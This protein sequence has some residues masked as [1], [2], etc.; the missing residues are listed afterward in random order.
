MA[1]LDKDMISQPELWKLSLLLADKHLDVALFPPTVREEMI[2]RHFDFPA[3]A[4]DPLRA[5]EDIIYENPLLFSD[6]KRVECIIDNCQQILTPA[7]LDP[8]AT[9]RVYSELTTLSPT[10]H[11][12]ALPDEPQIFPT[13][14]PTC[15]VALLQKADIDAFI[16]RTFYNVRF[17]SRLA[18]LIRY[19]LSLP[20]TPE[21]PSMFIITRNGRL[22]LIA[23]KTGRVLMANTFQY[24]TDADAAY[25]ILACTSSLSLDPADLTL[26]LSG[27][28]SALSEIVAPYIPSISAIPFPMLRHRASKTTLQA[29]F[30]LIIRPLCE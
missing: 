27:G 17:D 28:T 9:A 30:E 4:T 10:D 23:T 26:Y 21:T 8:E 25:Y 6:F 22:T 13:G 11:P 16:R 24:R 12:D 1:T 7:D 14:D 19:F 5:I 15:N 2:V 18:S 3:P 20:N 29:P